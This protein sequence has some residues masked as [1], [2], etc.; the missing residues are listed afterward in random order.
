MHECQTFSTNLNTSSFYSNEGERAHFQILLQSTAKTI[1]NNCSNLT[2]S[3]GTLEGHRLLDAFISPVFLSSSYELKNVKAQWDSDLSNLAELQDVTSHC[4]I[5]NELLLCAQF[6]M[7]KYHKNTLKW[8]VYHHRNYKY[9]RCR[10]RLISI[11]LGI[12]H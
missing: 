7:V 3:L 5:S 11:S 8:E 1:W 4:H 10:N 9:S 12:Y 6:S 2:V